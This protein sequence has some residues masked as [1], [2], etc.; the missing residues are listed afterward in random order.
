MKIPSMLLLL[1]LA[2]VG[3]RADSYADESK[4]AEATPHNDDSQHWKFLE[5]PGTK[6]KNPK[7][8]PRPF[9]SGGGQAWKS[10]LRR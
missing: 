6:R 10:R 4:P 3:A 2:G 5:T 9:V 8:T 7:T 1:G